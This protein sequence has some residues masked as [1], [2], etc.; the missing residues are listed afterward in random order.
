[1]RRSTALPGS[2]DRDLAPPPEAEPGAMVIY[3]AKEEAICGQLKR[4]DIACVVISN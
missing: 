2:N 1:M 4:G 3:S